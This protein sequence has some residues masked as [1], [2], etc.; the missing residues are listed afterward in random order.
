MDA[1]GVMGST[2]SEVGVPV[3]LSNASMAAAAAA[4]ASSPAGRSLIILECG[5]D[6]DARW[7]SRQEKDVV[8]GGSRD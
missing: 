3:P 6:F 7:W 2:Y 5:D 8:M 4:I 1:L